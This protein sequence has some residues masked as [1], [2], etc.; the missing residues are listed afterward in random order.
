MVCST[1]N[2]TYGLAPYANGAI[3]NCKVTGNSAIVY[4]KTNGIINIGGKNTTIPA[5]HTRF[6]STTSNTERY[7]EVIDSHVRQLTVVGGVPDRYQAVAFYDELTVDQAVISNGGTLY[8]RRG[9]IASN[10]VISSG[11]SFGLLD[12]VGTPEALRS[13]M[14]AY[15][16]LNENGTY[17]VRGTNAYATSYSQSG[18]SARCYVQNG[19]TLVSANIQEGSL[20]L[21]A[22]K[23]DAVDRG[24]EPVVSDITIASGAVVSTVSG[25]RLVNMTLAS[26][27]VVSVGVDDTLEDL[28]TEVGARVELATDNKKNPSSG[29]KIAG[30]NTNVASGTLY[31]SGTAFPDMYIDEAELWGF[32]TTPRTMR[33][34]VGSG[35]TVKYPEVWSNCRIYAQDGATV[36]SGHI[37]NS[38]N[39]GLLTGA[40]GML[41]QLVVTM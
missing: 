13:S 24:Q 23:A 20:I 22:Y 15:N 25:G 27:A 21:E 6:K 31:Y 37:Y 1:D 30:I 33:L 4:I 41:L 32:G 3:R 40:V 18:A 7:M 39:I 5:S 16:T 34:Q 38:G 14:Y 8:L 17:I 19:G 36:E 35:I 10:T 9:G 2:K 12:S 29:A 26:G 28:H 11:A